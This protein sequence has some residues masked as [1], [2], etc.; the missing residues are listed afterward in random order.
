MKFI[1]NRC[2][3]IGNQTN[4]GKPIKGANQEIVCDIEEFSQAKTLEEFNAKYTVRKEYS[5]LRVADGIVKCDVYTKVW[6]IVIDTLEEL[7][8]LI[9]SEGYSFLLYCK[10]CKTFCVKNRIGFDGEILIVDE[11]Y[12]WG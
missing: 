6:T 8:K 10:N 7:T 2:T 9:D 1:I 3:T 5:N 11:K 4:P 12:Y